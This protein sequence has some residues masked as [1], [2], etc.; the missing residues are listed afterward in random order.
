MIEMYE[1]SCGTLKNRQQN[2]KHRTTQKITNRINTTYQT[3]LN[4]F[5]PLTPE[6]NP[7]AQQ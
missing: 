4:F 2:I 3:E 5:N 1:W 7:S 6:L